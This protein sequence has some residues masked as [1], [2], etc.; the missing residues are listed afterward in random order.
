VGTFVL[1]LALWCHAGMADPGHQT[2]LPENPNDLVRDTVRNELN[3]PA[4]DSVYFTWKQ[5]TVKPNR[6][7]VRRMLET[8]A[9]LIARVI[10]INDRPLTP[11]ELRKEE[12]RINR[13]LDPSQMNAKRKEQKDDE[14]RTRKIVAVLPDAFRY[15]YAGTEQRNGQTFVNLKFTPN[16]RFNPPSRETL[17]L[18]G[19]Q[20]D[21]TIDATAKRIAKIDGT[22][23]KDVSIGWGI[24]GHLDKGGH[25]YVEQEPVGGG[26]WEITKML[27]NFNGRALIFKSIRIDSV[28]T[29]TDFKKVPKMSV[30]EALDLLRKADSARGQNGGALAQERKIR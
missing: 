10:S 28:D 25:F 27:L 14:D 13:L 6:T 21:M 2:Q 18:E 22:M 23:M 26:Q 24:I 5:R 8:P 7:I 30:Q 12:Q 29:A 16:P 15:E 4:G 17:V 9:G 11:E 1:G 20:G 19:M 3:P